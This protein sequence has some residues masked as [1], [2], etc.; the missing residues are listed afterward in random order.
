METEVDRAAADL[1]GG[2]RDA[3]LVLDRAVRERHGHADPAAREVG[4]VVLRVA[5]RQAGGRVL[6][7]GEQRKDIVGAADARLRVQE[8]VPLA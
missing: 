7:A 1:R 5:L 4:V 6:V 8:T 3:I 2:A